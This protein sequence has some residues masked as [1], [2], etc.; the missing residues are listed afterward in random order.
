M[1][2][3]EFFSIN[4][5]LIILNFLIF[6]SLRWIKVNIWFIIE[7]YLLQS[8]SVVGLNYESSWIQGNLY[9]NISHSCVTM[10]WQKTWDMLSIFL[11]KLSISKVKSCSTHLVAAATLFTLYPVRSY[12]KLLT[13]IVRFDIRALWK[14]LSRIVGNCVWS[15]TCPDMLWRSSIIPIYSAYFARTPSVSVY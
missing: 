4:E 15:A 6:L 2:K 9:F 11:H 1:P 3:I 8:M 7:S 5:F 14:G 10:Q 13:S 12:I